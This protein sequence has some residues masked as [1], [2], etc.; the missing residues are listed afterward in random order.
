MLAI[1]KPVRQSPDFELIELDRRFDKVRALGEALLDLL[2]EGIADEDRASH[3]VSVSIMVIVDKILALSPSTPEGEAIQ[4]KAADW[5]YG[6]EPDEVEAWVAS[7][8]HLA[9]RVAA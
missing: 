8:N 2:P 3:G 6:V 1:Q 4:R 5:G 7:R 9:D